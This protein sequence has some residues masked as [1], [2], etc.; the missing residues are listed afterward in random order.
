MTVRSTGSLPSARAALIPA[1]PPPM[2]TTR[3]RAPG[4]LGVVSWLNL[5]PRLVSLVQMREEGSSLLLA[6]I[7][8]VGERVGVLSHPCAKRPRM[9]GAPG[10]VGEKQKQ[11]LRL[12][13]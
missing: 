9:N 2:M 10:G 7:P 6:F 5:P 13:T 12:T 3:G 11:V 4:T 1:K 8:V